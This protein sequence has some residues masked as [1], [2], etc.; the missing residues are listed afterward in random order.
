MN[1]SAANT[2]RICVSFGGHA[3][4]ICTAAPLWSFVAVCDASEAS[5]AVLLLLPLLLLLWLLLR[6]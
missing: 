6:L 2:C 1:T 4:G 5:K 3:A